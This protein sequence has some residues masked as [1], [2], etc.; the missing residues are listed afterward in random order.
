M[1]RA[2]AFGA[3]SVVAAVLILTFLSV[4]NGQEQKP[5]SES[6]IAGLQ[7]FSGIAEVLRNPRCLNCHPTGNSPRQGDD[8]HLHANLVR[9]GPDD[10]GATGMPCNTCHQTQNNDA[11]GVPGKPNWHLAPLSMGWEGLS[12]H[13]LCETLK[14][15]RR[16]GGRDLAALT[17]HMAHDPLVD[18]GWNPG[19]DRKPIPIPREELVRLTET[20]ARAGAP[21]PSLPNPVR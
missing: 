20:W 11:S 16:N 3:A 2:A 12:D 4:A 5:L 8:R 18:H 15:P 21:C 13:D 1:E 10:R 9:R 14:D 17:D 6:G 7:A 19:A